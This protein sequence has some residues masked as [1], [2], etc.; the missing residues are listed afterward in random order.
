M[1]R[2]SS[3]AAGIPV[4]RKWG[5]NSGQTKL[6]V[7]QIYAPPSMAV[8]MAS[9]AAPRK[10]RPGLARASSSGIPP[11]PCANAWLQGRRG[12][13]FILIRTASSLVP[14]IAASHTSPYCLLLPRA[15]DSYKLKI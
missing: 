9:F 15:S 11:A 4:E 13:S 10:E 7:S 14:T 6:I 12:V 3:M 8:E 5:Q 1:K 2:D